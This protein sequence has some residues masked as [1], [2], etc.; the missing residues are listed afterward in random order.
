MTD[1]KTIL[2]ID[3]DPA[4]LRVLEAAFATAGYAVLTAIDGRGGMKLFVT[5]SPAIVVTDIVMPTQ[6][7]I[8]TIIAM[9]TAR[10]EVKIVA[11][12]GGGRISGETFLNMAAN[13]GA[14]RVIAKPFPPSALVALVADLI[15]LSPPVAP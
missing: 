14:D 5:A 2:L 9:K 15:L 4:L 1:T 3:D 6:E 12:S 7:G 8:E 13:L 10:P 11:M